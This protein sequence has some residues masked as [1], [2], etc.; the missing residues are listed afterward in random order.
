MA[1]NSSIMT[2]NRRFPFQRTNE[3]IVRDAFASA[4]QPL[5]PTIRDY[6]SISRPAVREQTLE[7]FIPSAPFQDHHRFDEFLHYL[8]QQQL[9]SRANDAIDANDF[10]ALRAQDLQ[11]WKNV[12]QQWQN[13]YQDVIKQERAMFDHLMNTS[14][15]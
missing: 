2:K 10:E 12:K 4:D 9:P 8:K 3:P 5:Y 13:Y 6:A 1:F 14:N 11:H 7:T 15:R